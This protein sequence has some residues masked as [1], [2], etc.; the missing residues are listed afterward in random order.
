[1]MTKSKC[2]SGVNVFRNWI[3]NYVIIASILLRN[4]EKP[5]ASFY[6]VTETK[7]V[8]TVTISV[9]GEL[10]YSVVTYCHQALSDREDVLLEFPR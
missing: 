2:A 9:S 5:M 10:L 1:M 6:T 8:I 7:C 3:N 4:L